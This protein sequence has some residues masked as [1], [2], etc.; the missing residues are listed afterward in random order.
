MNMAQC[1]NK[2]CEFIY[3]DTRGYCSEGLDPEKCK[4]NED[5]VLAALK[6]TNTMIDMI[7]RYTESSPRKEQLIRDLKEIKEDLEASKK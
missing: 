6:K 7:T 2:E 3:M 5:K 1:Q 4:G